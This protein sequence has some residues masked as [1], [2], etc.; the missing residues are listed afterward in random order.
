MTDR[1]ILIEARKQGYVPTATEGG[2][3]SR[4]T[5]A[6]P[7]DQFEVTKDIQMTAAVTVS[8][9]VRTASGSPVPGAEVVLLGRE[10]LFLVTQ[11]R[12]ARG[13]AV[14]AEGSFVLEAG[15]FQSV[16][17]RATASGYPPAL[18]D[19]VVVEDQPVEGVEVI[20]G[21]G[22]RVAGRVVDPDE[23]PVNQAEV[24]ARAILSTGAFGRMIWYTTMLAHRYA[25]AATHVDTGSLNA[26]HRIDVQG[27]R[28]EI[29]I[30][31]AAVN[32]RSLAWVRD[33]AHVEHAR[34]GEH[35]FYELTVDRGGD[36]IVREA[37]NLF[38]RELR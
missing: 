24:I 22:A 16:K 11:S 21:A 30:D 4:I 18:S 2:M 32:P 1:P 33:Y 37:A 7:P 12:A 35:A 6:L 8:G 10:S 28:G 29:Y 20:M 38:T 15:P 17:V 23:N 19:V 36:M 14:G 13:T 9:R 26:S 3:P 5:V 31:P 27:I 34:G 25:V